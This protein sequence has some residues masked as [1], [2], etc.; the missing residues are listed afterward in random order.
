[1]NHEHHHGMSHMDENSNMAPHHQ[2]STSCHGEGG[3]DMM[4]PVLPVLPIMPMTPMT[5]YFGYEYVEVLFSGLVINTPGEMAG[6]FVAI[7]LLAMFYEGLKIAREILLHK[8][9]V[10][11]RQTSVPV[12]GPNGTMLTETHN[13][14][15]QQ[16]LSFPHLL[17]TVL[18][19]IQVVFSYILM[20]IFMTYNAYLCIAVV[21]GAGTGYFLF[22]WKKAVVVDITEHCH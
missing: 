16:M 5:F 3:G 11:I 4:M 10:S 22:S 1:M 14:T 7:F 21:A 12:P 18:L 15:K 20:L 17:Q 8:S 13:K 2:S 9:Q 19:V 6:A